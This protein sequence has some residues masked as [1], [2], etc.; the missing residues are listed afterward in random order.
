LISALMRRGD[1]L[2]GEPLADDHV[3]GLAQHRAQQQRKP[4]SDDR[5]RRG[6]RPPPAPAP[7]ARCPGRAGDG[8]PTARPDALAQE[9]P[10]QQRHRRRD[11]GH[12]DAGGDRAEVSCTP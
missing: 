5:R 12:G 4:S 3:A 2:A 1:T 6:H 7:A 8:Q 9:Q 11:A 10:R